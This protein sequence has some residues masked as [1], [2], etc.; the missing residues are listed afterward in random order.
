MSNTHL[1]SMLAYTDCQ[2]LDVTGPLEVFARTARWLRD[3]GHS[4]GEPAY[5]VEIL[6]DRAGAFTCSNGL[7]L[8]A[9]RN[10]RDVTTTGTLLIAGGIGQDAPAS[11]EELLTWLRGMRGRCQR[12]GSVCTGAL[13]L[14]AAG[15]LDHHQ[16]TTHW[17]FGER[18]ASL[19]ND[20]RVD[21]NALF[22]ADDGIYTSAGV[23]AGMDLALAMVESDWNREVALAVAQELV[24]YV[25][26]SGGQAQFSRPLQAQQAESGRMRKLQLWM[27]ENL[28]EELGV[29]RLAG[30]IAMSPRNFSRRFRVEVGVSPAQYV[31]EIRVEAARDRL[32]TTHLPMG[33]IASLCGFGSAETMRR[34][35]NRRLGIAP[36]EYR[37]RFRS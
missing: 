9:A 32:E 18:L 14:G 29:E 5:S 15:L 13:V 17:A 8:I 34:A 28:G 11:N 2:I 37:K 33:K 16:A 19:G 36:T 4:H 24:M 23:T 3:H 22:T 7:Q 6:A 10:W 25:K 21:T 31:E 30:R 26:R 27:L 20:I 12:L 1:V 35:F